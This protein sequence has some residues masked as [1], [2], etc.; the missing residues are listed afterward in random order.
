MLLAHQSAKKIFEMSRQLNIENIGEVISE[1]RNLLGEKFVEE[2][3]E[4]FDTKGLREAEVERLSV[5]SH[6]IARASPPAEETGNA[7]V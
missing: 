4:S 7:I 2:E 1:F 3:L 5:S 6:P